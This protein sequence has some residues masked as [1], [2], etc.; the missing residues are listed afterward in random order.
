[1]KIGLLNTR[2][3]IQQ[4]ETVTDKYGNSMS[5]WKPYFSCFASVSGESPAEDS[6]AGTTT[7][8]GS[9]TFTVRW[10]REIAAVTS[11]RFRVEFGDHVYDIEGVDHMNY[12]G[13]SAKLICRRVKR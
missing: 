4:S 13:H 6:A 7:E 5:F 8:G 3:H 9:I 12:R 2:I 11:D 1:M 10:C